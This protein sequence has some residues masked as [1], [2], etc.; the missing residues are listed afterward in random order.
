MRLAFC[1]FKYYPYGGLERDFLRIA[2]MASARGH[3]VNVFTMQWTGEMPENLSIHI[4]PVTALTNHGRAKQFAAKLHIELTKQI[5]DC[6][7]GF[8]RLPDLDYY[9]AADACYKAETLQKHGKKIFLLPR[10]YIYENLEKAVFDPESHTKILLLNPAHQAEF[11]HYYQ[12]PEN[13]FTLL[14]PGI[15]EDRRCPANQQLLR[16]NFRERAKISSDEKII[17]M[18]GSDFKRK[19]VDRALLAFAS[20]PTALQQKTHLWI[21]GKGNIPAMENLSQKL[22]ISERVRFW[23]PRDDLVDFYA[24]ADYLLHPA[25]QETAG[26]VLLEA[27]TA[28]LPIIVTASCG[29]ASYIQKANAGIII[30]DPFQQKELNQQMSALLSSDE[31]LKFYRQQALSYTNQHD[32]FHLA[33]QVIE[34]IEN[35]FKK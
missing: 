3:E 10:Y 2:K 8:N 22:N 21:V 11:I 16:K 25:Y 9:F 4:I 5:F 34:V 35:D 1:L 26:M 19:G 20:L 31:K 23:G 28:G 13:R 15:G 18:V 6:V 17:L 32:F 30:S 33:T 7:I 24:A 27:M 14:T 29:Y 12:T